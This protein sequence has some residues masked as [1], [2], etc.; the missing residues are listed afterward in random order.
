[1]KIAKEY[2]EKRNLD[3]IIISIHALLHELSERSIFVRKLDKIENVLINL[4]KELFEWHQNI[5]II[6]REP[7]IVENWKDNDILMNLMSNITKIS[8]KY[9]K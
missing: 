1:L 7:G 3:G 2:I 5:Y 8:R 9:L 6:I 4:F